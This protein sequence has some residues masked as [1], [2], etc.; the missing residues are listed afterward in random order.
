MTVLPLAYL[1]PTAYFAALLREECTIDLGEHYV[2]QTLRNRCEILTAGGR[3]ALTVNVVKGGSCRKKPMRDVR[4]DSSRRWNHQHWMS[5][6][7]AYRRSP[8]FYH[9]EEKL[10]PAYE[11]GW[12]YLADLDLFLLDTVAGILGAADRIRLS[13]SYIEPDAEL[14]DLRGTITADAAEQPDG[15]YVGPYEQVF[16]DRFPFERNLSVLDLIFCEG[17]AARRILAGR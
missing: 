10:A 2:K 4:I 5:I 13:E 1:G 7:S 17:P 11:K 9:Y 16:S 3:A 8:Y 6:V 14:R 15:L 12:S